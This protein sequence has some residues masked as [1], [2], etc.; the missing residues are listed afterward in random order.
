VDGSQK[1]GQCGWFSHAFRLHGTVR[2]FAET[3]LYAGHYELHLT[4]IFIAGVFIASSCAV[5]DLAMDI[6]ASMDE[7]KRNN[8]EI[9]FFEH[10]QSG[11]RVGRA[12]IGTMT[13]TLFLAYS[14]SHITMFLLL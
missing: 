12:V 2:P 4:E 14:S 7:T 5:M 10:V 13:T 9:G 8:P 1:L 6:A 11:M 3:L